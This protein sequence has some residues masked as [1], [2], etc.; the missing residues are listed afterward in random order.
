MAIICRS[1]GLLFIM[2]PRTASS[3]VGKALREELEGEFLPSEEILDTKGKILVDKKHNTLQ[4]LIKGRFLTQKYASSLLKFTCVRNPFD[5][6]VSLY[7]KKRSKYQKHLTNPN[8]WVHKLPSAYIED[9]EFC[10]SHSFDEWIKK[11][12]KSAPIDY[13]LGRDRKSMYKKY[14]KGMDLVINFENI[15]HDFELVLQKKG[16]SKEASL[17]HFNSTPK[18]LGTYREYYSEAS[19]KI[20]EHVFRDDLE[21]YNYRF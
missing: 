13:V 19:R 9:M 3:A 14:V 16:I 12:Y 1:Y 5:S 18:K 6:L 20:I 2:T 15:S 7:E 8:S 21:R 11:N 4:E 10:K 17:T